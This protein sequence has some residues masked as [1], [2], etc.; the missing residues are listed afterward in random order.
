[1]EKNFEN[2]KNKVFLFTSL[3]ILMANNANLYTNLHH[4]TFLQNK[5][6]ITDNNK[7]SAKEIK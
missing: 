5:V 6:N 4:G 7:I 1:L 3:G 2:T